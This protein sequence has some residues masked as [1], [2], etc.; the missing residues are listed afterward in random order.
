LEPIVE[1][2]QML[3]SLIGGP[4]TPFVV[5]RIQAEKF[6]AAFVV[7]SGIAI[8][9][10]TLGGVAVEWII[11]DQAG[12]SHI[13]FHL[14]GGGY[15]LGDPA[16]SRAFT[17]EFARV[18]RC[19]V[20]SIDYRL[21]PEN[22]FP[23]A[24]ED[25]VAAY[26]AL[27]GQGARSQDIAIGGESAGGGL[28]VATLLAAR[29]R[30][31]P[32]PAALIAIS[33]WVD[34]RCQA[35]SFS[36]KADADP[37]LTQQSLKEM[38]DAYLQGADPHSALASPMLANLAGLP[39]M[40]IHVGSEEVLLD[41]AMGLLHAARASKVSVQ[42]EVWPDMIHVWHMFHAMLPTG[43]QAIDALAKFAMRQWKMGGTNPRSTNPT[44]KET[45]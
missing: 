39:P 22:P 28:A 18:A 10:S 11:P 29:D 3:E 27:L 1:V 35:A 9:S 34:M 2:R 4:N 14:H 36:V 43:A 21:A 30:N 37:L 12:P 15:V 40:L 41:D 44:D 7:P 42:L 13:F 26:S 19:R 23:A 45:Q 5:R 6:A 16:G 17:C 20:V 25:A 33:P 31:L 38:A 32:M 24:V 8:E